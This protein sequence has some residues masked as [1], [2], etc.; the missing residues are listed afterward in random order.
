MNGYHQILAKLSLFM[1]MSLTRAIQVVLNFTS[2]SLRTKSAYTQFITDHPRLKPEADQLIDAFVTWSQ[3]HNG[4][5]DYYYRGQVPCS[6]DWDCDEDMSMSWDNARQQ[7][8]TTA[9]K[10]SLNATLGWSTEPKPWRPTSRSRIELLARL[11]KDLGA[12][13]I[14]ARYSTWRKGYD[15]SLTDID[16]VEGR[17]NSSCSEIE[18]VCVVFN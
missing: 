13:V 9:R 16:D 15:F 17:Q 18:H 5:S 4:S 11:F 8:G 12:R 2:E 6:S 14:I 1:G 7:M 10:F 3:S